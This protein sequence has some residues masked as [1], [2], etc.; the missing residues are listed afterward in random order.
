MLADSA[1]PTGSF[2]HSA[3][4][5]AASQLGLLSNQD[6]GGVGAFVAAATRS[7]VQQSTPFV[8]ASHRL[9][10]LLLSSLSSNSDGDDDD[11]DDDTEDPA[12]SSFVE[13]W[14]ELD[15]YAHALLATNAPACRASLDQGRNLLRLAI[16]L[17][18][19]R[20]DGSSDPRNSCSS[21][22]HI[23][24]ELQTALRGSNN[25]NNS[26][27]GFGHLSTIFGV[28]TAQ[29]Q[30][31]EDDACR[32]LG[33]CIARDVV[34]AGVRLNL[35]GPAAGQVVLRH[36]Q[37]SA[38]EGIAHAAM[39]LEGEEEHATATDAVSTTTSIHNTNKNAA[40]VAA[41]C[42]AASGCAP[43]LEAAH[44]CHDLLATRLF[45]T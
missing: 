19:G 9:L 35:L 21:N 37:H 33:Y 31:S 24:Q 7:A 16:Q 15:R 8:R 10:L 40:V 17:L 28:V 30:L 23:L 38:Q 25:P 29:L 41:A 32:L 4:L 42:A 5:E 2:A 45:R 13:S 44:C 34:S 18:Q 43:V 3:G 20:R 36:A 39:R 27:E 26:G 12:L 1:L 6:G 22:L 14:L 11:D